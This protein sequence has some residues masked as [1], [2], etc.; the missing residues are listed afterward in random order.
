MPT[1]K[2][3]ELMGRVLLTRPESKN[4]ELARLLTAQQFKTVSCPML[5]ISPL[6]SPDL[7]CQLSQL[8]SNDIIIAV[9]APAVNYC[10]K[11]ISHWPRNIHYYA[12]GYATQLALKKLQI[13]AKSPQQPVTE[14]LLTESSLQQL[15]G[16]RVLILRGVGGRE[17]LAEQLRLRGAVVEYCE[18]YRREPIE[19]DPVYLIQS[20]KN[21]NVKTIV[22]TS[23]EIL[24]NLLTLV[25]AIDKEWLVR[26]NLIVP[27]NRVAMLAQEIGFSRCFVAN[28][29]SN[30]AISQT[31]MT[32][33]Q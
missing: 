17:T 2:A 16:R 22:V 14:S 19:Y 23:G 11:I 9:S 28:G 25:G 6:A 13:D 4:Q 20:W 31:L 12:I 29:A 3:A 5:K 30:K 33:E 24:K 8:K 7:Q 18:L 27:S 32:I 21:H 10:A 15:A 1:S 26:C